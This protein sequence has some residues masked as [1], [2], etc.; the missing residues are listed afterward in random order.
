MLPLPRGRGCTAYVASGQSWE[1]SENPVPC[2]PNSWYPSLPVAST[3]AD[4]SPVVIYADSMWSKSLWWSC[5]P[6]EY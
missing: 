3:P 4:F 1:H 6:C 5:G 2:S